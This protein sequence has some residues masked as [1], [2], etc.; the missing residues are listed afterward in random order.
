MTIQEQ[1]ELEERQRGR[2]RKTDGKYASKYYDPDK[3]HEYY[4]KHRKIKGSS[5]SSGSKHTDQE[6]AILKKAKENTDSNIAKLR[7]TVN[8]WVE[9]QQEL[10]S[11]A[12]TAEEKKKIRARI[13]AVKKEMNSQIKKAREIYKKFKTAY[14]NHTLSKMGA[15]NGD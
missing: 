13:R 7:E 2:K 15:D 6:K 12:K 11:N 10:I 1:I 3:A 5:G 14:Q 4:M 9:K 8:S